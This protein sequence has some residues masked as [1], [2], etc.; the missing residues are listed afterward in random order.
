MSRELSSPGF[1]RIARALAL[2]DVRFAPQG[3]VAANKK[4]P[5]SHRR[6]LEVRH[7]VTRAGRSEGPT[8]IVWILLGSWILFTAAAGAEQGESQLPSLFAKAKLAL[9]N[10]KYAAAEDAYRKILRLDPGMAEAH[11]NLG[12]SLYMQ[13]RRQEAIPVLQKAIELNPELS[14][15][16]FLLGLCFFET[17]Q[18]QRAVPLLENSYARMKNENLV[19]IQYLSQAYLKMNELERAMP[20]LHRWIELEPNSPDALYFHGQAALFL[21]ADSFERLKRIAPDSVRLHQLQGHLLRQQGRLEPAIDEYKK[22]IAEEPTMGG[23][24]YALG[25]LYWESQRLEE[26][27]AELKQ[28]LRL[29]PQDPMTHFLLGNI[30]LQ[31]QKLPEAEKYLS[32]ALELQ[33]DLIDAKLDLARLYRQKGETGRAIEQLQQVA[34]L[35]PDRPDVHYLLF[36]EHRN[37]GD[38]DQAR[39]ELEIF[40]SL[41]KGK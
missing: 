36:E 12:L 4:G 28:E 20:L 24:H 37:A 18:F 9:E 41:N 10:K 21:A 3:P 1:G 17:N 35:D 11:S 31:Q 6:G 34:R 25:E 32:R 33:P 27:V 14:G 22:A 8:R 39:K 2:H 26:A 29:S 19:V 40:Q 23:L 5:E 30:H 15:P 38:M 7:P 13:G 16:R